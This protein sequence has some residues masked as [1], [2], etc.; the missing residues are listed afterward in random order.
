MPLPSARVGRVTRVV[1]LADRVTMPWRNGGGVTHELLREDRPD[2]AFAVRL[3]V[4]EVSTEGPFSRFPGV[5]RVILLLDGDDCVLTRDDGVV[6]SLAGGRPFAFLGEDRWCCTLPGGP[7]RDFNVMTD[8]AT[9]RAAVV[10]RGPGWVDATY[11]LALAEGRVGDERLGAGELA[12]LEGAVLADVPV[13][14]VLIS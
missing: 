2:G 13:V 1:R 10:V 11:A 6:V 3:S 9:R 7:V 4:A 12:V 5:D 8:R 14:A